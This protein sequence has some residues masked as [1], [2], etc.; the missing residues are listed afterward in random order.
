MPNPFDVSHLTGSSNAGATNKWTEWHSQVNNQVP[1]YLQARPQTVQASVSTGAGTNILF[2]GSPNKTSP[3]DI[4]SYNPKDKTTEVPTPK[5]EDKPWWYG[6]T[7]WLLKDFALPFL[8]NW[9]N[10]S[11]IDK[12]G[13]GVNLLNPTTQFT[14]MLGKGDMLAGTMQLLD[15]PKKVITSTVIDLG[16]TV[17]L[18]RQGI[19]GTKNTSDYWG[20]MGKAWN[21]DLQEQHDAPVIDAAGNYVYETNDDGT[22]KILKDEKGNTVYQEHEDGTPVLDIQGNKVPAYQV[23][24]ESLHD[25][26]DIG[27]A[28][29][30]LLGQTVNTVESV[31]TAPVPEAQAQFNK[32]MTDWGFIATTTNFDIFDHSQIDQITGIQRD[33]YGLTIGGTGNG[34]TPGNILTQTFNFAGDLATDPLSYVPFGKVGRIA[35]TGRH[36]LTNGTKEMV[37][38]RVVE[39]ATTLTAAAEGKS[40]VYDNFLRYAANNSAERITNHVV[41]RSVTTGEREQVAYLLGQVTKPEDAAKVL[42]ATEYGSVRAQQELLRDYGKISLAIDATHGGGYLNR[43]IAEGK[44]LPEEDILNHQLHSDFYSELMKYSDDIIKSPFSNTLKNVAYQ[45]NEEGISTATKALREITPVNLKW[46]FGNKLL[47]RLEEGGANLGAFFV[48]GVTDAGHIA[49]ERPFK[50]GTNFVLHQI[51]RLGSKDAKGM[52]D[53]SNIDAVASGKFYGALNDIDRVSKGRLSMRPKDANGNFTGPSPKQVLTEQWMRSNSALERAK[54]LEDANRVGLEMIATKHGA[55]EMAVKAVA[56]ELTK[57]KLI[58]G[59]NLD[60]TGLHVFNQDGKQ[61]IY[62]DPYA[63]GKGN[64]EVNLWNWN[65]VDTAFMKS[66]S[67][68][69]QGVIGGVEG[70][71]RFLNEMNGL[72]NAL[73]VTRGSRFVRD[74]I[75]N[76][77]STIGS[78]YASQMFQYLHP[79]EAIKA[80]A[81]KTTYVGDFAKRLTIRK[82]N[83]RDTGAAMTKLEEEKSALEDVVKGQY[84]YIVDQL[85]MAPLETATQKDIV[86][87]VIANDIINRKI[88]YHYTAQPIIP[89]LDD[90][91]LFTSYENPLTVGKKATENLSKPIKTKMQTREEALKMPDSSGTR[92]KTAEELINAQNNGDIIHVRS[93]GRKQAWR[94]FEV[95]IRLG[96]RYD[97]DKYEYRIFSKDAFDAMTLEDVKKLAL[98]PNKGYQFRSMTHEDAIWQ[99]LTPDNAAKLKSVPDEIIELPYKTQPIIYTPHIYGLQIDFAHSAAG[100]QDEYTRLLSDLAKSYV[101]TPTK[102][103]EKALLNQMRRANVGNIRVADKDGEF[104]NIS[105]PQWTVLHGDNGDATQVMNRSLDAIG[106]GAVDR[107]GL[108][109]QAGEMVSWTSVAKGEVIPGTP[110]YV[111]HNPVFAANVKPMPKGWTIVSVKNPDNPYSPKFLLQ[112][113]GVLDEQYAVRFA[114]DENGK[115]VFSFIR[116]KSLISLNETTKA[117]RKGEDL[118]MQET[119]NFPKEYQGWF[120]TQAIPKITLGDF[121]RTGNL[122]D[123]TRKSTE[124]IARISEQERRLLEAQANFGTFD[125]QTLSH[126]SQARTRLDDIDRQLFYLYQNLS[127]VSGKLSKKELADRAAIEK[128]LKYLLRIPAGKPVPKYGPTLEQFRMPEPSKG[129]AFD[130][131]FGDALLG[132]NGNTWYAKIKG[133]SAEV[134]AQG[135]GFFTAKDN[136]INRVV[137]PGEKDYWTAWQRTLNEHWRGPDGSDLDPVIRKI[138][139]GQTAGQTDEEITTTILTWLKKTP[140]GIKYSQ[141]IGIGSKFANFDHGIY[142]RPKTRFEQMT[143]EA[144]LEMQMANVLQHVGY[145]GKS[146]ESE[147]GDIAGGNVIANKLL[148]NKTITVEDLIKSRLREPR[149]FQVTASGQLSRTTGKYE[150]VNDETFKN[151]PD[152]WGTLNDP[153]ARRGFIEKSKFY[154]SQVNR[155]VADIPQ[156]ILFQKPLFRATYAKSLERQT[157]QMR[158]ATGRD[159]FTDAELTSMQEKARSFALAETRKW[160]Y[161]SASE[162]NIMNGIRKVVPFANASVFTAKWMANVAKERPMYLAWMVYEYNKAI[163]ATQWFDR[164]GNVVDYNAKDKDGKPVAQYMRGNYPPGII[165]LLAGKSWDDPWAKNYVN[166]TFVSRTSI[167]PIFNGNN[168]DLFGQ[169]VPNPFINWGLTPAPSMLLSELTKEAY[170]NPDSLFGKLGK[171]INDFNTNASKTGII[172]NLLPFGVSPTELSWGYLIPGQA[173]K[174]QVDEQQVLKLRLDAA[175]LIWGRYIADPEHNPLPNETLIDQVAGGMFDLKN[176]TSFFMPFAT[177]YITQVDIARN[178]WQTYLKDEQNALTLIEKKYIAQ[179]LDENTAK[180][181][182]QE[183]YTALNIPGYGR[184]YQERQSNLPGAQPYYLDPYA[185]AQSKFLNEHYDLFYGAVSQSTGDLKLSATEKTSANLS[186]YGAIIPGLVST[187]EG[188]DVASDILNGTSNSATGVSSYVFDQNVYNILI[189]QQLIAKST[190]AQMARKVQVA[191]GNELFRKGID[192]NGD[193]VIREQDGDILG[194]N[195][196]DNLAFERNTPI[197]VDKNLAAKKARLINEISA[198]GGGFTPQGFKPGWGQV[199]ADERINISPEKYNN[200]ASAWS[201]AF[202]GSAW[203]KDVKK[204]N[205]KFWDAATTYL[206]ERGDVQAILQDRGSDDPAKARLSS[207]PDLQTRLRTHV[208]FLKN[209]DTTG[210]FSEWYNNYFEGDTIN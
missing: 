39:D 83:I 96:L 167:D 123:I 106:F 144:Y 139:E 125:G 5:E 190:P 152:I 147:A 157:T 184:S 138:L 41:M 2:Q 89:D 124:N 47:S 14:T 150:L 26:I 68:F 30:Y 110:M 135:T 102:E 164:N 69:A 56:E 158:I 42:L 114:F 142:V 200:Y 86:S 79:V 121:I 170:K 109:P 66:K 206:R 153:I 197:D 113:G 193:G 198:Q 74:I 35:F 148:E 1:F 81:R 103:A 107:G 53:V 61:I 136:V 52:I 118:M 194:M 4:P 40:T 11:P 27:T 50:Y 175:T 177:K 131:S 64:T 95:P 108:S 165:N 59:N 80:A 51:I 207:N 204:E 16:R 205:F 49:L 129:A 21:W 210:K 91:R 104:V 196:L 189:E 146:F 33:K 36:L 3:I 98:D 54:I 45:I 101:D 120:R 171:A 34:W 73:V 115:V 10:A 119:Q 29:T 87:W 92:P 23:K 117:V 58:F 126:I 169:N 93:K 84:Q 134:R 155:V 179:G 105:D 94:E 172:P 174:M 90:T 185:V 65:K 132:K 19:E 60:K 25:N 32:A 182:A 116:P 82:G 20:D 63:V 44:L 128:K 8:G 71:A 6:A 7:S 38:K 183:E 199:W 187:P 188:A 209:Y 154:L 127:Y 143:E 67:L 161:S 22:N 160:V 156:E 191:K 166:D 13:M 88:G 97:L 24:Y 159:F 111:P 55:D 145:V 195:A 76:T 180:V 173:A 140:E 46:A 31:V 28:F 130:Q 99:P 149:S 208:L 17:Q 203:S 168:F 57:R 133:D 15:V 151:L 202:T 201:S 62:H 192:K 77:V 72:F 78:G 85:A 181:K 137:K 9:N 12:V 48:N 122:K 100:L 37:I 141:E 186:K 163:N 112:I 43:A 162:R 176:N 18:A 70:S 178:T 75:A